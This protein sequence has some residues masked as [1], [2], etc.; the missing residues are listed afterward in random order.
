MK[1]ILLTLL[2]LIPLFLSAKS[3]KGTIYYKKDNRAVNLEIQMPLKVNAKKLK[4]KINGKSESIDASTLSYMDIY[5]NDGTKKI[6]F[7]RGKISH[8]KKNGEIRKRQNV[9]VWSMITDV[10]ENI[11]VS[12]AGL[13]YDVKKKK[14]EE[15]ILIIFDPISQGFY[16]SKANSDIL[17]N[18][19][20]YLDE[21]FESKLGGA[22]SLLF[23]ECENIMELFEE[24]QKNEKKSNRLEVLIKTYENCLTN[25]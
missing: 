12:A 19:D 15:Y 10:R 17:V 9:D 21:S 3:Y 5:I 25:N 23:P 18:T 16:L 20:P 13:M 8:F 4:V 6:T 24:A 2:L 11:I 7:K 22:K 14:K 1:N